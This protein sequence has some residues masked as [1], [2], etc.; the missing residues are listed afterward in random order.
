[1]GLIIFV[2]I[3]N[4]LLGNAELLLVCEPLSYSNL[5]RKSDG[6][7]VCFLVNIYIFKNSNHYCLYPS[8][9]NSC[10]GLELMVRT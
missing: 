1:M 4:K 10:Q 2:L 5:K 3:F 9:T 8:L 7:E 6:E